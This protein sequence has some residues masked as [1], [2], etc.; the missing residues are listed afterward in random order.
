MYI[1]FISVL[2]IRRAKAVF[3]GYST[4]IMAIV[5]GSYCIRDWDDIHLVPSTVWA[6]Q[7]YTCVI[8]KYRSVACD[9]E[10]KP[11]REAMLTFKLVIS[12]LALR[13]S[14]NIRCILLSQP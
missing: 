13:Q 2:P 1:S 3:P 7:M 9:M 12:N 5:D 6:Q 14:Y 4:S 11:C 10:L 8:L